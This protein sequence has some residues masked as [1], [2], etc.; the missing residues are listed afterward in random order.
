[1]ATF[2][3]LAKIDREVERRLVD[4]PR[5]TRQQV[6]ALMMSARCFGQGEMLLEAGEREVAWDGLLREQLGIW[7]SA[8][9]GPGPGPVEVM[10]RG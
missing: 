2:R 9:A 1:M 10:A 8:I 6:E 5:V 3:E 4:Y 7:D